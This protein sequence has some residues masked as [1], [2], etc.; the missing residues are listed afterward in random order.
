MIRIPA[1]KA[2]LH[3]EVIPGDGVVVLS[4][5]TASALQGDA[6]ENLVPLID[7]VRS[8][9][10]IVACLAGTLDPATAY[11]ALS[12]MEARGL[13]VE[14]T[15]EISPPIAAFWQGIGLDSGAV[16]SALKE[17]C[18]TVKS[19]SAIGLNELEVALDSMGVRVTA[20]EHADLTVVL[21]DDYQS[22]ELTQINADAVNS[23]RSWMLLRLVGPELWLGPVFEA[24]EDGC[25]LCLRRRLARN[26]VVH[27]FVAARNGL[28]NPPLTALGSLPSTLLAG[29]HIA[30]MAV[31]KFL[32]GAGSGLK[33]VIQSLDWSENTFETHLLLPHPNCP[34][35]GVP[36]VA[37]TPEVILSEGKACF[38]G[39]GGHRSVTP[40]VTLSTYQ[41]LVSPI[42]GVVTELS[43]MSE[44]GGIFQ[45]YKGGYNP[46]I[47]MTT[48]DHL[49]LGLRNAC[50][51]KGVSVT[52]A[53]VSAL[54][55]S[56]ERYSSER[57]GTEQISTF[58]YAQMLDYHG[59]DVIHPNEIMRFSDA[60][61]AKQHELNAVRSKY[62]VVPEILPA[63][64][65]IDWTPM[66]SLSHGRPKYLPT[67]LLYYA[68]PASST[69]D[70]VFSL[71]CSNGCASGNTMEEAILHGFFELVERDAVAIWWYNR[72]Q[73]QGVDLAGF[74][75]PWILELTELYAQQ[76]DRDCW[77][78][79]L[80]SD[81]GIPVFV[82]VSRARNAE[83]EQLLFGFGCHLDAR[84]ALQRAYAE[85]N[86]MLGTAY[87]GGGK[88]PSLEDPET[89]EWL[90]SATIKEQSYMA[91]DTG[92]ELKQFSDYAIT[93]SGDF[94][95]DI[96][97]CRSLIEARGM[98]L[99][100]LNQTRSDIQM[101]VVK[102]VVPGLRHF[103][104]RFG[105]GRLYEVPAEMGWLE[106]AL[107]EDELNPISMFM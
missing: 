34:T 87:P 21:T 63:N 69:C 70:R 53:K 77:A 29:S 24:G 45:V 93:H 47:S 25:W 90:T 7:G 82:A 3:L 86:Q 23:G 85:M 30:A 57:Q 79:D 106:Q 36:Q 39:D 75:E 99:L 107:S 56:I 101:P 6:Y 103:W 44:V 102:V 2:N 83:Q 91:P 100:V 48:L 14:A 105:A 59:A 98:E 88:D 76:F 66:W 38:L 4:E 64:E 97:Y 18:V 73:K 26:R 46:A 60:Q 40:E 35:C 92:Q 19:V 81:L 9:E 65:P 94:L 78:L 52:Q 27:S 28:E 43:A 104:A 72:L 5:S 15:P 22:S 11:Y 67:Q 71:G 68:S 55:E 74:C 13:L 8:T 61:L 37:K 10:V 31:A 33:G 89:L 16:L 54:C 1:F 62:N 42:V 50:C 49:K 41:H 32:C 17:K 12:R 51:G 95:R 20:E 58:S 96:E 84:I 80:T